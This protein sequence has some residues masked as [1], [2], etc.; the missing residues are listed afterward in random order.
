ML[1]TLMASKKI[2]Q[3]KKK[4]SVPGMKQS[5]KRVIVLGDSM[6]KSVNGWETSRKATNFKFSIKSFF[7]AKIKDT[8]DYI[9]PALREDPNHFILHIGTN[10]ITNASKSD[11]LIAEEILELALKFKSKTHEVSVSKVIVQ[12]VKWSAKS[13][14]T[15]ERIMQ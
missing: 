13:E 2:F 3:L 1:I 8:N 4:Q 14:R 10:D 15:Y 5:F 12:R 9:K 7:G 6:L 11:K